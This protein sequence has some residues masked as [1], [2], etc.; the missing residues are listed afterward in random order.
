MTVLYS[1]VYAPRRERNNRPWSPP[2]ECLCVLSNPSVLMQT[3]FQSIGSHAATRPPPLLGEM[4]HFEL[5]IAYVV[6]LE[7]ACGF[8]VG[9]TD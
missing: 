7:C 8:S 9:Y 1:N 4:T 6:E 2:R 5:F 3:L